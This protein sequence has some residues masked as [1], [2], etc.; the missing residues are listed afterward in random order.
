[1]P[2][3]SRGVITAPVVFEPDHLSVRRKTVAS[4]AAK[5]ALRDSDAYAAEK[6]GSKKM[7]AKKRGPVKAF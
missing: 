3:A 5:P 1:L 4:R 7:G 2:R 6:K